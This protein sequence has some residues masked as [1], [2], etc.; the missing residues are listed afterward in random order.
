MRVL[1]DYQIIVRQKMGGISRYHYELVKNI[2]GGIAGVEANAPCLFFRNYYFRDYYNREP[3]TYKNTIVRNAVMLLNEVNTFFRVVFASLIGKK[4]DVIHITWYKPYY[5]HLIKRIMGRKSPKIVLTVHDLVHEMEANEKPVMKRGADDREKML[6]IAD[7]I[8]AISENTKKDLLHYYPWVDEKK[9]SVIYHGFLQEKVEETCELE[10]PREYVFFVGK[11][12]S[13]KNFST[14][15]SA[16]GKAK[17]NI[18]G[19]SVVCAGGGDF[20]KDELAQIEKA[21]LKNSI[22]QKFMTDA[23]LVYCYKHAKC[24]VFP[25]LYEGFGMPILEAFSYD[26]PVVL[27]DASCFPEIAGDAGI[28]FD[29]TKA[30]DIAKKVEEVYCMSDKERRELVQRGRERLKAFSWKRTAEET[31]E[32][33]KKVQRD[34]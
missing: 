14:F 20:T 7:G 19:L 5:I 25:S 8:I 21:G 31:V 12:T 9:I 26:C 29:G 22:Q 24:Y 32:V 30:D 1:H 33:Y 15:V 6:K 4:Y 28:Y 27:S 3:Y 11:R 13:Y 10:L 18:P 17:R 16:M 23:E 2:N 34:A